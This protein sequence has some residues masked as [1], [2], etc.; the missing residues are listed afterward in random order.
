MFLQEVQC[1]PYKSI[2]T[3]ATF[4]GFYMRTH[5]SLA[6]ILFE[7]TN[8]L[9]WHELFTGTTNFFHY[10]RGEKMSEKTTP[11]ILELIKVFVHTSVYI[12]AGWL[13]KW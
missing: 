1:H 4:T 11:I 9:S 12:L 13:Q 2:K 7:L 6:Y 8:F 10:D 3:R 5:S